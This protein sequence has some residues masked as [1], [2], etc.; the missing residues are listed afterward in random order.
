MNPKP[1]S[2]IR[3][4]KARASDKTYL[5]DRLEKLCDDGKLDEAITLTSTLI[6]L[7]LP[8]VAILGDLKNEL[9]KEKEK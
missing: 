6:L 1:L 7:F 8:L 4:I 3:R 9:E 5:L 2:L